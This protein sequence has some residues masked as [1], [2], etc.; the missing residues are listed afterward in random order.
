MCSKAAQ[1]IVQICLIL[2]LL[3]HVSGIQ[4]VSFCHNYPEWGVNW[5]AFHVICD[6]LLQIYVQETIFQPNHW[7]N[8]KIATLESCTNNTRA[9]QFW[10]MIFAFFYEIDNKWSVQF[11]HCFVSFVT[12]LVII[13]SMNLFSF[14]NNIN[15][16]PSILC[17]LKYLTIKCRHSNNPQFWSL[18]ITFS[19]I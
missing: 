11:C 1:I 3:A 12:G 10:W 14:T 9:E 6:K 13:T 15:L 8:T 18:M 2:V 17:C 19:I 7:T 4:L 16:F 5:G